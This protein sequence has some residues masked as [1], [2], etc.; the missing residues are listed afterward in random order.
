MARALDAVVSKHSTIKQAA[1]EY[2]VTSSTL[3]DPVRGKVMP[4]AKSG[5]PSYLSEK[6]EQELVKFL[7]RSSSI[8]YPK[9]HKQVLALVQRV[10]DSKHVNRK[11]TDGWWASFNRRHPDLSSRNPAP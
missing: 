8:G 3:G 2:S 9:T 5:P 10:L 7:L 4:G 6:E 1:A 11:V